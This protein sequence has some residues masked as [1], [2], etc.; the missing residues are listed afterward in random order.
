LCR[1]SKRA[2]TT[3]TEE[4]LWSNP[5]KTETRPTDIHNQFPQ[6]P[7]LHSILMR[8]ARSS[9]WPRL[10]PWSRRWS[11]RGSWLLPSQRRR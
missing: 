2:Q 7:L 10:S 3:Q 5:N 8:P 4:T 1:S 11:L 9:Y 6:R